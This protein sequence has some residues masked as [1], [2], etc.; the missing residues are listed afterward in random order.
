LFDV[1]HEAK[2]DLSLMLNAER[3]ARGATAEFLG[4]VRDE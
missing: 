3:M 2:Q 1:K 4:G